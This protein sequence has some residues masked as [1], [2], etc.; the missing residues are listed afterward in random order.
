VTNLPNIKSAEK[1][2]AVAKAKTLRNRMIKSDLK[3]AVKKFEK[4]LLNNDTELARRL[5]SEVV[6]KVDMAASKG[7]IHKNVANRKK[8][9]LALRLNAASEN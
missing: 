7:V 1:R 6:K 8:S 5:Y 4:V 9:K 2:V 3:T